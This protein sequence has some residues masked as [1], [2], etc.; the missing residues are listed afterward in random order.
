MRPLLSLLSI[1]LFVTVLAQIN[2]APPTPASPLSSIP[3]TTSLA[4]PT[5]TP[6]PTLPGNQNLAARCTDPGNCG[7]NGPESGLQ[8]NTVTST[9]VS[10]TSVPCYIT[11]ITTS[12]TTLI[13]TIYSTETITSTQTKEGTVYIIQYSPTPVVKSTTV[14]SVLQITQTLTSYWVESQGSY[15]S[16]TSKG[17]ESTYSGKQGGGNCEE[18]QKSLGGGGG[19]GGDAWTHV[20]NNNNV[21]GIGAG[22]TVPAPVAGN[23]RGGTFGVNGNGNGNVNGDGWV[24]WNAAER[25][26]KFR[27]QWLISLEVGV[28]Y[29][30]LLS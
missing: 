26:Q 2:T 27:V 24:S 20:S 16:S 11:T 8:A 13:S 4:T 9:I 30:A 18:C 7:G 6:S 12:S 22:S 10:I 23:G 17:G 25:R 19:N 14:K 5:L 21:A 28:V 1:S 29:V 3:S 15:G